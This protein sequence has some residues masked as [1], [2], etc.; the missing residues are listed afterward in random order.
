MVINLSNIDSVIFVGIGATAIMDFWALVA[1]YVFNI[2]MPNYCHIGRWFAYMPS[3]TFRHGNITKSNKKPGECFVGWSA[4]YVIGIVYAAMLVLLTSEDWL[5]SP[6]PLPA[7]LFA[8]VT[9][10]V[11]F[12]IMQPALGFGIAANKTPKPGQA[13]LKSLMNHI[14]FGLGLYIAAISISYIKI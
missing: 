8:I 3:A 13:R 10:L 12:F 9:L 5:T 1:R 14:A 11:P 7:L 2:A 6:T 4:H